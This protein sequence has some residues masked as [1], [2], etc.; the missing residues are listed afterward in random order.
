M[1]K[2]ESVWFTRE[3]VWQKVV[4]PLLADPVAREAYDPRWGWQD[5]EGMCL[6]LDGHDQG[7]Y[8]SFCFPERSFVFGYEHGDGFRIVSYPLP[9]GMAEE[10]WPRYVKM[11]ECVIEGAGGTREGTAEPRVRRPR[12]PDSE[13]FP[14]R[15]DQGYPLDN[16]GSHLLADQLHR[17]ALARRAQSRAGG[18]VRLRAP[19]RGSGGKLGCDPP[20]RDRRSVPARRVPHEDLRQPGVQAELPK[21]FRP[22]LAS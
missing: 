12:E 4:E 7:S 15:H 18:M 20:L 2:T 10:D 5:S 6:Y 14:A 13:G 17:R 1:E 22:R 21:R 9:E 3:E 8:L 19:R 16:G 11:Y